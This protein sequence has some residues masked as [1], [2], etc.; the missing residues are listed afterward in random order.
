MSKNKDLSFL[1]A[2]YVERRIEQRTNII[3]LTLFG[4][5]IAGVIG[6]KMVSLRHANEVKRQRAEI[7][8]EFAEAARRIEQ[9]NELQ[10]R[11]DEMLRKAQVTGRLLEPMP[12]TFLLADLINRMPPTLSLFELELDSKVDRT[13]LPVINKSKAAMK[14]KGKNADKTP[15]PDPV[16]QYVVTLK[17]V[18]VAPTDVQV[19]QYMSAL[20]RSE[21][22]SDV[23][24]RFS[25]ESKIEDSVMRKFH[26]DMTLNTDADVRQIEPLLADRKLRMNPLDDPGADTR[27]I[28]LT[29]EGP[30]LGG[31]A[32][33][34]IQQI[35]DAEPITPGNKD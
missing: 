25:E 30:K 32:G 33:S 24:L 8:A 31:A 28:T 18:G 22:L 4:V 26:I 3:C 5:V 6:A 14:N 12:R 21:V 34:L 13:T 29:P 1:P 20:S 9:L 35:S 27:A 7:N 11:K 10:R 17:L 19:A 23:N 15:E 2:D 16:P